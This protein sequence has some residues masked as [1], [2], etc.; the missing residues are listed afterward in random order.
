M[1][2]LCQ[3]NSGDVD[4][5]GVPNVFVSDWNGGILHFRGILPKLEPSPISSTLLS[6]QTQDFS[7]SGAS[8]T[9]TA[10]IEENR[11]GGLTVG[12]Q[13][14]AG[15]TTGVV[16]KIKFT[17]SGSSK[18]GYAYVNVVSTDDLSASGKA[19]VVAGRKSDDL[20]WPTTN[21][22]AH[23]IYRTLLYRGF[24]KANIQYLNPD[25][26]QDADGNGSN[27][28][29]DAASTLGN[30]QA[31]L[32]LFADGSPNLLV[33]LID[34]GDVDEEDGVGIFRCN[35]SEVLQAV[36]L[37]ELLD[38]LQENRSVD[39]ITL[40]VDCCRAGAFLEACSGAPAGKERIV[41]C[42]S[43]ADQPSFFSAGGLISFT[44]AFVTALYSGLTV[45]EAFD[46]GA[47]AM[48]RYQQPALDDDGDGVY[49]PD[50]DGTLAKTV[51]VGATF[52]A[53]ADR[54]QIGVIS[55]NQTLSGGAATATIWASNV[56][57]VY[58]IDKVWATIAAP[59]FI[60]DAQID[61][62]N[63][64]LDLPEVEL[65]WNASNER[66]EATL[67]GLTELGAYAVNIYA[68]DIWGGVSYPKQTYINQTE[69]D[70]Q[71]IVVCGEGNYDADSP[72]SYS[73]YLAR[74][75]YET[76]KARWIVDDQITY[77][78]PSSD[79]G[80]D[81]TPTKAAL[82]SAISGASG[83]GKLT[84]YLVG[85]GSALAFDMDGESASGQETTPTEL[86]G[87]LD[88]LQGAGSTRVLVVLDFTGSGAWIGPLTA[89]AG[90]E[91]IIVASCSGA[92]QSWCE[93]GGALSFSQWFL[94]KV[95]N[96]TNIRD[97]FTWAR[98]AM[99]TIS[100]E[101][102]NAL[103]DD[104][105]DGVAGRND[106]LIAQST[107]LGAA[108]VT[109]AEAP[110]L[111]DYAKNVPLPTDTA[112]L[113]ATGV[114]APE[115][116]AEVFACVINPNTSEITRVDLAYS[117]AN[118]RWES[119]HNG[120]IPGLTHSVIYFVKDR[121]NTLSQPYATTFGPQPEEP[122]RATAWENY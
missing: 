33:Y 98:S 48:D 106:G 24:S 105:G 8:G 34:H 117:A 56:S 121:T 93:E 51:T 103:L 37:D 108:F 71:V 114:R 100:G 104:D 5:D 96:G 82:S 49:D 23:F 44:N 11:S 113:W 32:T 22:L 35:E 80:V 1:F 85:R 95:F 65:T 43:T 10:S 76:A 3:V 26:A 81:G 17:D 62:S 18:V 53:G 110:E 102:Q 21:N 90:Q 72:Q 42:S 47:G 97:A 111:G 25:T 40:V 39:R 38:D 28:D 88:G 60:P 57:S 6:S 13:Y 15:V 64:V 107:Y 112:T 84:V 4:G 75:A 45:G 58:A 19:V 79:S 77:L 55:P 63:P 69:S 92:E 31:A 91:R 83:I 46:L 86:D 120:F 78:S 9:V 12:L 70:E 20:L 41:V 122:A 36:D 27:D 94:S 61:P 101:A 7:V 99:R 29:I 16:D 89:S 50:L 116:I 30:I 119:D 87:W 2:H 109:G 54:P 52:I 74:T 14:T 66:Y 59:D 67:T 73:E 115:G 118:G 68:E